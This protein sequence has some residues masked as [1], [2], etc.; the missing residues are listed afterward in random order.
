MAGQNLFLIGPPSFAESRIRVLGGDAV[1]IET[2]GFVEPRRDGPAQY[3]QSV[4]FNGAPL[5][6]PWLRGNEVHH[7]A[8]PL[9][10]LGPEP[11]AWGTLE[12]PPSTGTSAA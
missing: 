6:R 7:G 10:R 3:V 1:T 9:H 12:R 4:E 5:A 8:E 11:S 2:R